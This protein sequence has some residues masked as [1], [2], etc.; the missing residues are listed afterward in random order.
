MLPDPDPQSH[1]YG[2]ESQDSQINADPCGAGRRIHNTSIKR[3]FI[4]WQRQEGQ[5]TV[6]TVSGADPDPGSCA[7]LTLGSEIRDG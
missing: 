7:F 4:S 1:Q 6:L 3:V 2:Y 5:E